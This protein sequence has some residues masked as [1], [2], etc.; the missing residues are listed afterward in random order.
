LEAAAHRAG[1]GDCTGWDHSLGEQGGPGEV[2]D[3]RQELPCVR[4]EEG[5]G[6]REAEEWV[7]WRGLEGVGISLDV[8]VSLRTSD[9]REVVRRDSRLLLQVNTERFD[10]TRHETIEHD[11]NGRAAVAGMRGIG[12]RLEHS[13]QFKTMT[14]LTYRELFATYFLA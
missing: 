11:K 4:E 10:I 1:P 3:R 6:G 2:H 12:R 5:K 7:Q 8:I 13:L 14:E 9:D